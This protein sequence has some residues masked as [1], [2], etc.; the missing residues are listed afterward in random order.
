MWRRWFILTVREMRAKEFG[1]TPPPARAIQVISLILGPALNAI[2]T[3]F[4]SDDGRHGVT[5]GTLVALSS[6]VWLPGLLG[7][8]EAVRGGRPVLG[9]MGGLLAVVGAFGGVSFGLQGFYEGAFGMSKQQ[10]LDALAAHPVA[11]QLVLWLPASRRSLTR[12]TL[13]YSCLRS[14]SE[15]CSSP[16]CAS[17]LLLRVVFTAHREVRGSCRGRACPTRG[18]TRRVPMLPLPARADRSP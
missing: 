15:C 6:V 16:A 13:R 8:W 2:A 18:G 11:S 10:S 7:L 5:G 12:P 4:W 9:S 17:S 14:S 3:F 1:A